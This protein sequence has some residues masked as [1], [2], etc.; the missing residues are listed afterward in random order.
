MNKRNFGVAAVIVSAICF[1]FVPMFMQYLKSMGAT[2]LSA[3]FCRFFLS[4]LPMYCYLKIKKVPMAVTAKQ[5]G[6]ICLITVAGYG[7]TSLLLF[8]SYNY[9]PTG[10]ATTLHFCYPAMVIVFSIVFL[11]ERVKLFKLLS[12][13]MCLVGMFMF[14]DGGADISLMGIFLAFASG[15]TYAFYILYLDKSEL[16]NMHS[17][18]LIV[19]M[20]TLGTLL[21]GAVALS[22]GE[23]S[24]SFPVS[25]WIFA[26]VF[27]VCVS[28][29]AVLG[30]QLGVKYTG[31]QSAAILSTLEPITSVMVGVVIYGERF[32][33]NGIIGCVLIL[34]ATV[35]V[36]VKQDEDEPDQLEEKKKPR[37][38]DKAS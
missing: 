24:L 20:N 37:S 29:I 18:K 28:F 35:I 6:K 25:G 8:F 22:M 16:K 10:M 27:A 32:S 14:Y 38:D 13:A 9:I 1:G 26:S 11:R 2:T 19:Y 36:A 17:L 30:F 33:V 12:V 15:N 3:A 34:A 21:T 4:L 7:G 31:A 5:F 23:M